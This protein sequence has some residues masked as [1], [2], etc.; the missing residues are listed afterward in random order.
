ML[1]I[2]GG[3]CCFDLFGI[4]L[5]KLLQGNVIGLGIGQQSFSLLAFVRGAR[6]AAYESVSYLWI[7]PN[8][9]N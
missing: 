5:T 8:K 7:R 9:E 3:A 1:S 2:S 4:V 6:Y